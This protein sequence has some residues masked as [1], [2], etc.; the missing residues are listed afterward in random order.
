MNTEKFKIYTNDDFIKTKETL[1]NVFDINKRIPQQVFRNIFSNF[2]FEEF[3]WAMTPEFWNTIQQL[4]RASNDNHVIIA[5]LD[6]DPQNY[7]Y[8]E[9]A[10]YNWFK[11]PTTLSDINYYSILKEGPKESPVDAL[12]YNT[13]VVIWCAPSM[14]WAIWGERSYGICILGFSKDSNVIVP[15]GM[16]RSAHEAL[17]DLIEANFKDQKIPKDFSDALILN[18][19]GQ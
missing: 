17:D 5:T 8:K 11:L 12:L 6:P 10:F 2:L 9:F 7:F 4:S 16:W 14:K 3:D 15:Q 18:Y 13:E 1:S 19:S